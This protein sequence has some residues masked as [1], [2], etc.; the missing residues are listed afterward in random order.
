MSKS[1]RLTTFAVILA[2]LSMSFMSKS[3]KFWRFVHIWSGRII[4]LFFFMWFFSGLVLI[5][6]PYPKL[7]DKEIY[8]HLPLYGDS[9]SFKI[10]SAEDVAGN[11]SSYPIVKRDILRETVSREE[12]TE[13]A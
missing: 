7:T 5:Y 9:A 1:I 13:R 4:V 11:W 8:S 3:L 12:R 2:Y 6:H 10:L